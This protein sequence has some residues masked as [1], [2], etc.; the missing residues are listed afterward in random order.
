MCSWLDR[1]AKSTSHVWHEWRFAKNPGLSAGRKPKIKTN[2]TRHSR[3]VLNQNSSI[4]TILDNVYLLWLSSW[5]PTSIPRAQS[6]LRERE[7]LARHKLPLVAVRLSCR[8]CIRLIRAHNEFV[9]SATT[10]TRNTRDKK[11][12][13]KKEE[14]QRR[15][16]MNGENKRKKSRTPPRS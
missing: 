7:R 14:M 13:I 2:P 9:S 8:P 6:A 16:W 4:T 15:M 12:T 1:W 5:S 10:K 11:K 3:R